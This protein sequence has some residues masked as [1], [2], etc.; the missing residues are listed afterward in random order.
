MCSRSTT[1]NWR[2]STG[3]TARRKRAEAYRQAREA[4]FRRINLDLIY[5]L[6]GQTLA[7][8]REN[9]EEALALAPEH[10]SLYALTVEEGTKLAYDIEHGHAPEP[11]G[12]LQAEMYSWAQ[13]RLAEAGYRQYEISNWCLPGE[14][15]RHNLVYWRNGEWLGLGPGAHSHW[16]G[17]RFADVYSPRKYIEVLED[18]TT[19]CPPVETDKRIA[20]RGGATR[21]PWS[22]AAGDVRRSAAARDADG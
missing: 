8:W 7:D 15:C 18:C 21:R 4:G 6:A 20:A 17:F 9:V 11:D 10:L 1:R 2:R 22:D 12:D 13:A 3:Y 19:D 14:E 16:G 5:G